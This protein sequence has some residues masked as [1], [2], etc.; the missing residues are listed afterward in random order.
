MGDAED[1]AAEI[2][3]RANE[4]RSSKPP[5][6]IVI[7]PPRM[8]Q[9]A[10]LGSTTITPPRKP[11]TPL[12]LQKDRLGIAINKA[13][14]ANPVEAAQRKAVAGTLGVN[15][16]LVGNVQEAK[17]EAF[18]KKQSN[19]DRLINENPELARYMLA[20]PINPELVGQEVEPLAKLAKL[21]RRLGLDPLVS[22]VGKG[23][24]TVAQG[25][26]GLADLGGAMIP[27]K[28]IGQHLKEAGFDSR[29]L[30]QL[31]ESSYSEEQQLANQNVA[32]AEGFT[33]TL[34]AIAENPSTAA[35]WVLSSLAL[36]AGGGAVSQTLLKVAP[37]VGARIAAGV[38]EGTMV[39]G[40]LQEQI[41]QKTATGSTTPGQ[42]ALAVAGGVGTGIIGGI[43]ASIAKKAG[44]P[45]IDTYI[46]QGG[47]KGALEAAKTP[48]S[49]VK[50]VIGGVVIEGAGQE[51]PQSV[52][53]KFIENVAT[54]MPW[55]HELGKEAAI[56]LVAG[57]MTQAGFTPMMVR[58]A[59]QQIA[60]NVDKDKKKAA[61]EV[62][63]KTA[64]GFKAEDRRA[65][66]EELGKAAAETP[67]RNT[68]AESFGEFVDQMTEDSDITDVFV[69][70]K[71]L[72][73]IFAQSGLT[74]KEIA[75]KMPALATELKIARGAKTDVKIS[76][77]D[78]L[79]HIA[80]TPA[81]KALL[82][83]LKIDPEGMSFA[84]S[85]TFFQGQKADLDL[86]AQEIVAQNTPVLTPEE[87]SADPEAGKT[88][89]Q[90][91][92]EHTNTREVIKADSDAV[93]Q[94]L[95]GGLE[96]AGRFSP[97]ANAVYAI[98]FREF[99]VTT[100]ARES[101]ALGRLVLPSEVYAR[102][103][104]NFARQNLS[105]FTQTPTGVP[106]TPEDFTK[107][108]IKN[109]LDKEDWTIMA[110][111]NPEG[112]P[113]SDALNEAAHTALLAELDQRGFKY[114][115][116]QGMYPGDEH[117]MP[118]VI[119]YNID[120]KTQL[121]LVR[122]YKQDSV[123]TQAGFVYQDGHIKPPATKEVTT[124]ETTEEA[125][126]VPDGG[127]TR[128]PSTGAI[129]SMSFDWSGAKDY[130]PGSAYYTQKAT[131]PG[132]MT[133]V[134]V[135]YS[136]EART[137]LEGKRFGE[138]LPGAERERLLYGAKEGDPIRTRVDF[139][140]DIGKGVKPESGLGGVRH[141][142]LLTNIY[143]AST[144][145]Q[146][147]SAPA[148][149][150][151]MNTFEQQV[152]AAG[153]DGYYIEQ[154]GQ[155]RVV[156]MG[157]GAEQIPVPTAEQLEAQKQENR[158][159]TYFQFA[160]VLSAEANIN[161]LET[162]K[163]MLAQGTH[164]ESVRRSTGW[165]KG[166]DGQWRYEINDSDATLLNDGLEGQNFGDLWAVL[167]KEKMDKGLLSAEDIK[168]GTAIKL[169]D[170]LDHP[171][172]FAAYPGL[173]DMVVKPQLEIGGAYNRATNRVS[174]G[175]SIKDGARLNPA[176][177]FS[178]L[179]HE[180]QHAIQTIEG[181]ARGGNLAIA[182]Y[183]SSEQ[184]TKALNENRA[185]SD[186]L[187]LEDPYGLM[188][189]ITAGFAVSHEEKQKLKKWDDLQVE[190][191]RI[192]EKKLKPLDAYLRLYGE[193]EARNVQSRLNL[194]EFGRLTT[195]I[196]E[197]Y[198]EGLTDADAVVILNDELITLPPMSA[199]IVSTRTPSPKAGRE[200]PHVSTG[201]NVDI[202]ALYRAPNMVNALVNGTPTIKG[203]TSYKGFKLPRS[204][205]PKKV[206]ESF[207]KQATDN[208]LWLHDQVPTDV[209]ERSKQWYDGGR[210]L[211]DR[212]VD[213]HNGRYTPQQAAAA[214]ALLSPQMAWDRNVSLSE[215]LV[216]I[217][218]YQ[219][220]TPWSPEMDKTL[221]RMSETTP[222]VL[223]VQ[224]RRLS[225]LET[226]LDRAFWIR[227]Y[228]EAHNPRGY[229]TLT[230]EGGYGDYALN[231][232]GSKA[233]ASWFAYGTMSKVVS[234]LRDGSM[235]N[236]SRNLGIQHK[237]RNF[238]NNL[239]QPSDATS[240]TIDTH[241]VAAAHLR[242]LGA[243]A[244]EVG[245]SLGGLG[246][247]PAEGLSGTYT[248]YAE[249]YR[250]A[251]SARG[252]KAREMQSITWE[253]L[254]GLFN[255]NFKS[256]YARS[257]E[258]R[259]KFDDIATELNKGVIDHAEARKQILGLSGGIQDPSWTRS[260]PGL[261]ATAPGS[262][263]KD[264]LLGTERANG[265]VDSR[266]RSR[267]APGAPRLGRF[268]G[269]EQSIFYSALEREIGG[270]KNIASKE[271]WINTEQAK[272]WIN[273]RQKEG[274]FKKEEVEAI[275]ILDWLDGLGGKT[276]IYA[277]V[278]FVGYNGIRV[279]ETVLSEGDMDEEATLQDLRE[280]SEAVEYDGEDEDGTGDAIRWAVRYDGVIYETNEDP[281]DMSDKDLLDLV[282]G[283][284]PGKPT[285]YD[286]YTVIKG[287]NYKE[288]LLTLPDRG[289]RK[290]SFPSPH[291]DDVDNILAHT[292][293]SEV[294]VKRPPTPEQVAEEKAY[295]D[296]VERLNAIA[297]P[298]L[299]EKKATAAEYEKLL[300]DFRE[301][302]TAK[303]RAKFSKELTSHDMSLREV[304][305]T[306]TEELLAW[307]ANPPAEVKAVIARMDK[308]NAKVKELSAAFPTKPDWLIYGTMPQ[309]VLFVEEIQSDWA[310]EGRKKGFQRKFTAADEARLKELKDRDGALTEAADKF[311]PLEA[312]T[313]NVEY[314]ALVKEHHEIVAQITELEKV[315]RGGGTPVAP[316]VENTKSWTALAV[317]RILRYAA[318][319]GFEKVAWTT[320]EQQADRY[321]LAKQ[322][323]EVQYDP[324]RKL[325]KARDAH[326]NKVL[327]KVV[328]PEDIGDYIGKELAG[329]LLETP[330]NGPYH[331]LSGVKDL[332][333]GGEGMKA[334]YDKMLPQVVN[335]ILKKLGGGKVGTVD[336]TKAGG[337]TQQAFDITPELKA[338]VMQGLPLFQGPRAS[339]DPSALTI[340][341]LKG[342]DLSSVI[343]EGGHFYLEAL[344]RMASMPEAPQS[345]KDDFQKTMD[346]F[347]ISADA[348]AQM[349][350]EA[351][352]PYHEQWA[353]SWERYALEGKAPTV[354]MQPTF[355]RF[356]AW[357][358]SVYKSMKEFLKQNPLAGRLND[359]VRAV[360]DRLIASDEAIAEAE[361]I[362]GY[363]PLFT[364]ADQA[365]LTQEKFQEY[366][367][368]GQAATDA[369]TSTLAAR[370][371]KDMQWASGARS[372]AIKKLQNEARAK[373]K[374]IRAEVTQEV[375]EEPV[376]QARLFLTKGEVTQDDGTKVKAEAGFKLDKAALEELY[377]G[378]DLSGLSR[379]VGADGIAP[380]LAAQMFAFPSGQALVDA[381]LNEESARD[382]ITG[383]TDQRMLERYGDL[384]DDKAIERAADAAIH[385][386]VRAKFMATGL[387]MLRKQPGAAAAI[388]KAARM[389]AEGAL[390]GKMIRDIRP[391]QFT[392][393][394]SKA[395]AE[396][397]KR[398]ATNPQGAVEAQ[399]AALLNNHMARIARNTLDEVEAGLRYVK[400]FDK[401]ALRKTLGPDYMEQ[402][403]DL[404]SNFDF[405]KSTPLSKIDKARS[406]Q[407]WIDEQEANGY[408]PALDTDLLDVLKRK[409]YKE[410]TAEEF[411]G[412]LDAIKQ[413]EHI[414]RLKNKL[415]TAKEAKEFRATIDEAEASIVDNANRTVP[416]RETPTDIV[417]KMGKWFRQMVASHRKFNSVIREM[418]G[419]KNA[420]VM[421]DILARPMNEAGDKEVEMRQ[422]AAEAL[423]DLFGELKTK[424]TVPGN[425]YAKKRIVPGTDISMTQEQR[426]M[427]GMNWGNEGNRQRLMDGGI[428]GRK[429]L[430]IDEAEAILDTLTKEEW[431]FIQGTLD[432]VGSYRDQI[433]SLERQLTGVEP[434]WIDPAP[435]ETK[436]GT[437][438]GGYFPA[439]YDA[440]MSTRSES[441]DAVND[442]RMGMKGAFGS[443]ATRNGYT[444]ERAKQVIGRPLLLSFNTISQHVSEVTHRLAWQ[445]W[446]ID[447]NRVLKALDAPIREHYGTEILRE[448][449][450]TVLDIAAGDIG[451][452]NAMEA[453]INHLRSGSTIV[454]MG[455]KVT[456]ALLQPSGLAQSWTRLGSRWASVGVAHY[457]RNPL[458]AGRFVDEK[459]S[460][461]R[462]RGITMQREI[463]E[464][465]NTLRSGDKVSAVTGSYFTMIGKMQRTVDIPTW[466]GAYERDLAE[467]KYENATG[468]EERAKM[469]AHAVAV[470]DQ[471]VIDTQSGGQ[472]KDLASIQRGS[473]L[474]KLFTNFYSYFSATYNLNVEAVRKTN[475]RAPGEV[476]VLAV[477][478][479]LLNIVPV[480]FGV[481][482]KQIM[483]G[484]CDWD[485]TECLLKKVA[486][487]QISYM[488]GQMIILREVAVAA[489]AVTG[490]D[491]YGYQGP[492][493]L[494]FFSDL[495][496]L[497]TQTEQGDADLGWFKAANSV[498]GALLHYPAGQINAT[499][500]GIMALEDGR[501]EGLSI[502]PAL[503][504]G[505][506]KE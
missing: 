298:E 37:H 312:L 78:Y 429:A 376:N 220:D 225:E 11:P 280:S 70:E 365:G 408:E 253:A 319:N 455:W 23:T 40:V 244:V 489:Q 404:L 438:K 321:A 197:T 503:I 164:P 324:E 241:A 124:F 450:N 94:K 123:L 142:V 190:R 64:E 423:G 270:L 122:K 479:I 92:A 452:R 501:V 419:F 121:E 185:K 91:L 202:E 347:G 385:N 7:N 456:T 214:F 303:A 111:T 83:H 351:R 421:W 228:D 146:R 277:I 87:Y 441:L 28:D 98:P 18:V 326:D 140:T 243:S 256:N 96:K 43:G 59:N 370:S 427:F 75:E 116:V 294:T 337:T 306:A 472:I 151:G 222:A 353:Q 29:A 6:D 125:L 261:H 233:I 20:N 466:L 67:L 61:F 234:V 9:D 119:I 371:I 284:T 39:A 382:K 143:D 240:V 288:L 1:I 477:D 12:D 311:G 395:N 505:A 358:L 22:L 411:T 201:L 258:L 152:L 252:L 259:G 443:S 27:G 8:P 205:D 405:R 440:D 297:A 289:D 130:H 238:Y 366:L 224:G 217:W 166:V 14:T 301:E 409:S 335:D 310:Q 490:G 461:M 354:E 90:Y 102:E 89:E 400:K 428:T 291:F 106:A 168:E 172:L 126:A 21:G 302:L 63:K 176:T 494:R 82:D 42:K 336:L 435:I 267:V 430:S 231:K 271:G 173:R 373:R 112:K 31:L 35:H 113:Q 500:D 26:V 108:G 174:I 137:T 355:A 80:G 333:I 406:L 329:R 384:T 213:S 161:K 391:V 195:P 357:M 476:A 315:R 159:G 128:V 16:A 434:K 76:M 36:L 275:G 30:D 432:F 480:L 95:L 325:L 148:T 150:D 156:M 265:A 114:E 436:F 364:S 460:L 247:S 272:S 65:Q 496:K 386:R 62:L 86:K 417:G 57:S 264:E 307:M 218:T 24:S 344:S 235:P 153:Y 348:W 56:G 135:H 88:Y 132:G 497:G 33:G 60:D 383:L 396:A 300:T 209:R 175:A 278:D 381:L 367:D 216:D 194:D 304:D 160:G 345:V 49:L 85:Q 448:M 3:K 104:L 451:P 309:R 369:A 99:F 158:L 420:G 58:G 48:S 485:D 71:K 433:A 204:K 401:Q 418:D 463:N 232:G 187:G 77:K 251:A 79:T 34:G 41:R 193:M 181:F 127:Y 341:L 25:V 109:I 422:Q 38:G 134:G 274:K 155:G 154:S 323:S 188:N 469:E 269:Y 380:D 186:A 453:A 239:V 170:L 462:N 115:V 117:E 495:Y 118:S 169:S 179:M 54:G 84:E 223:A 133:L 492:A 69:D 211:V 139:Y 50:A 279:T 17:A 442:M 352:R 203:I 286:K 163:K 350:M 458:S 499:M 52:W 129:F 147:F 457:L 446:L 287:E 449:R 340:A 343:H 437:Y 46:A 55:D 219:Q 45:D 250:R 230:P 478:L 227:A 180:V 74:E 110:A 105:G 468:D 414:A 474:Q 407:E 263:Y 285:Q 136:K 402:I 394:E 346:W 199:M 399:R 171:A 314:D 374:E 439:K 299:A 363:M 424:D 292:R 465:L 162:A 498:G 236:I 10:E 416:E 198:N 415:L 47:L 19:M 245:N 182:E 426:I 493:G 377:P 184:L 375:M 413:I 249:A 317:K 475:F 13:S 273:A 260:D 4:R 103:P 372:A 276:S 444:K 331:T 282:T 327:E 470:A 281:W 313:Q 177:I 81:E 464:V 362:R 483:K 178:I 255:P 330:L 339:F 165:F 257:K 379:M 320:G 431:D 242:P 361:K 467:Q 191:S 283:Y 338:T 196:Q 389:A 387:A 390:A 262:S 388:N 342:A 221:A 349:D 473:P 120:R 237:V 149:W 368:M 207:I 167:E 15:P 491:T 296:E 206:I 248:L 322:I 403:D 425:L 308:A 488:A 378:I 53:E 97:A 410:M 229:R 72:T 334:F 293:I 316:F 268:P 212:L 93:Y 397:I 144:N 138:G 290:A 192:F 131:T 332:E 504:A 107:E 471:T 359:D 318:E 141:E 506:P 101:K 32:K 66:F 486:Q 481:A 356:R 484:D 398:A 73:E 189:R 44:I 445:P 459:S 215:R 360:F 5:M 447:A 210:V 183:V 2:Q 145:P 328:E 454:G 68:S 392:A 412:I 246:A 226:D 502:L 295:R 200:D 208:L 482:L 266:E 254:R 393:A 487:E 157:A 51:M 100:A 305:D